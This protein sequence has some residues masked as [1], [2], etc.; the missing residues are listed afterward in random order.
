MPSLYYD[1]ICMYNIICFFSLRLLRLRAYYII[2]FIVNSK[3]HVS[4]GNRDTSAQYKISKKMYKNICV[5]NYKNTR[6]TAVGILTSHIR[7][8]RAYTYT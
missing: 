2:T 6:F 5:I 3:L 8:P 7:I 4:N 1:I